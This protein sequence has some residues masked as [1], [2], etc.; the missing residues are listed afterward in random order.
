[1]TKTVF[2]VFTIVI[3]VVFF[4]FL[5]EKK[6]ASKKVEEKKKVLRFGF[7]IHD[8]IDY[9]ID[10]NAHKVIDSISSVSLVEALESATRQQYGCSCYYCKLYN[11]ITEKLLERKHT[12]LIVPET[13]DYK[14]KEPPFPFYNNWLRK[15]GYNIDENYIW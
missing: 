2:L 14:E 12:Y 9:K 15:Y 1:M 11:I 7:I 13:L 8:A 5:R 10:E 3:I 6:M 4:L